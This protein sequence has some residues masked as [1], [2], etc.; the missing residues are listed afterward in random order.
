MLLGLWEGLVLRHFHPILI[1]LSA[2]L[3]LCAAAAGNSQESSKPP[4]GDEEAIGQL[5]QRLLEAYN[6]GQA[7]AVA[8]AFL[9]GGEAV[10]EEGNVYQGREQLEQ[11]FGKFF[12]AFPGAKMT[13]DAAP[14]RWL[15]P[16]LAVEEGMRKVV[17]ADGTGQA[18]TKYVMTFVKHDGQ[19][20]VASARESP[21]E[22]VPTPHERLLPLA[23]LVG[24]WVDENPESL[25]LISC[26]WSEDQNF[27]LV[28]YT[29]TTQGR[30]GMKTRQRIG[31][32]PLAK[33]V[34]SWTFDSDGGYGDAHWTAIDTGW[35]V[36]S[37]AV[38]PDGQTGSATLFLQ[39]VDQ[40]RFVLRGFDRIVGDG[41]ADDFEA[42][43]DRRPPA[44]GN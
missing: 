32:D 17:T 20:L 2:C 41:T 34:R 8:A 40:D 35:V 21:A 14:L 15:G 26:R 27:L 23:W 44:P 3:W 29:A 24:D 30:A 28:D 25:M 5:S 42:A 12:A 1:C 13:L 19:W 7:Q 43:I 38:L 4:A 9:P 11:I 6:G 31:W 22:Q 36:K 16:G 37:S 10:D 18:T 39:P 33:R